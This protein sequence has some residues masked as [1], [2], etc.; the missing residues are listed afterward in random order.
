MCLPRHT[1]V[2]GGFHVILYLPRES[3]KMLLRGAFFL[4]AVAILSHDYAQASLGKEEASVEADSRSFHGV[5]K[6]SSK[7]GYRVHEITTNSQSIREY[8]TTDG[9]VFCVAWN[10]M[11]QP[12]LTQLF[13]SFYQE[14]R[15]AEAKTPRPAGRRPLTIKSDNVVVSRGGHMRDVRGKACIPNLTPSNIDQKDI[16]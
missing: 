14:Y 2:A 9:V 12:D 3:C 4:V 5:R 15:D 7:E 1:L 8:V 6:M 11:T 16:Q 10:G 13:G